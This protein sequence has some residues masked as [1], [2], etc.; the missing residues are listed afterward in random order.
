MCALLVRHR[1]LDSDEAFEADCSNGVGRGAEKYLSD[2]P[3]YTTE[4][5]KIKQRLDKSTDS[6]ISGI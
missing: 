3:Y 2:H 5:I 1:S 6:G 4:S